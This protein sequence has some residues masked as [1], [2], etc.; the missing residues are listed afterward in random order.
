MEQCIKIAQKKI[1][2]TEQRK[3]GMRSFQRSVNQG[4]NDFQTK[5]LI[6]SATF[7]RTLSR[8]LSNE[9]RLKSF[10]F[11]SLKEKTK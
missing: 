7:F 3:K 2:R 11:L 10:R 1:V 4:E 9:S 8:S 5:N 6:P